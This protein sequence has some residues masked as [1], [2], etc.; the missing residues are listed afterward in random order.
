MALS[1]GKM[2]ERIVIQSQGRT[3]DLGGGAAVAWSTVATTWA[4]IVPSSGSESFSGMQVTNTNTF[5]ITMRYRTNITTTNRILWGSRTFN[6][7]SVINN[8]ERDKYLTVVAEEG[9]AT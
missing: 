9:V 1:V 4:R 6:I 2:R 3:T 7:R 8:N 5:E